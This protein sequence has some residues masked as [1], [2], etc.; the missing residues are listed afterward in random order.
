[1]ISFLLKEFDFQILLILDDRSRDCDHTYVKSLIFDKLLFWC[2]SKLQNFLVKTF[3]LTTFE[4]KW[5]LNLILLIGE[6]CLI[7]IIWFTMIVFLYLGTWNLNSIENFF[8]SFLFWSWSLC[9][10]IGRRNFF[11]QI[12]FV[13]TFK[14]DLW[15]MVFEHKFIELRILQK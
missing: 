15:F 12:S 2:S 14:M 8:P 10:C 6:F 5:D 1:M 4:E 11:F 3:I 13:E 7:L 9:L